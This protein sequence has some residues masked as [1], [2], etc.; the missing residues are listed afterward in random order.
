[1]HD[2]YTER[3]E[4]IMAQHGAMVRR[5]AAA[6]E[7]SPADQDDLVQDIWLALWRALP[8]F[9]G[10]AGL[11]T[12]V[13]RI[14]HNVAV[15]HVRRALTRL[16]SKASDLSDDLADARQDPERDAALVLSRERLLQAVR[17]LPLA[18][19]QPM[20]LH[21]EDMDNA[22]IADALGLSKA[23]V[24]VRLTRARAALATAMGEG[25]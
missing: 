15:S 9:R 17:A 21:L 23:N 11:K 3:L 13:A 12:Y 7:A 4:E 18:L 2:G 1:V 25:R 8:A 24:A 14:A 20:V 16:G 22:E 19:R 10:E 5:I 6:H